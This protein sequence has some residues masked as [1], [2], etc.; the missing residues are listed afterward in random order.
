MTIGPLITG[1]TVPNIDLTVADLL[2]QRELTMNGNIVDRPV[3][4]G[5]DGSGSALHAA[6][7]AADEA[8]RLGARLRLVHA[9]DVSALAW[10][11]KFG[12]SMEFFES[13]ESD[14]RRQLDDAQASIR[15]AHPELTVDAEVRTIAPAHALV[16]LSGSARLVVLGSRG[17]GGF[18]GLLAGSTAIA[19]VTHGHCPVA[20][21]RGRTPGSPPPDQGPVVV[22]VDGSPVS[23]TAL[24]AAFEESSLRGTDLV[25]VHAWVEFASDTSYAY[26]R[27]LFVDWDRVESSEREI[28][29]ERLAGWQE[30]YPNVMVRRVVRGGRPA[31]CLLHEA[32]DA[33]LLVVGS[34]G[35]GGFAG[36][37]LGSTSH[38]LIHH[39]S[40]P[41]LVVRADR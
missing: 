40:C 17:S 23:E 34:R 27:Q 4:A 31:R 33:Q 25:A 36:M 16:D 3:V 35:R 7:W 15:R 38:A 20:V 1:K 18:K 12:P 39:A 26:A 9:I 19:L 37:L 8:L 6:H 10:T 24:A 5:V 28:L 2:E 32:E 13:L 14:G 29:A 30:K 21:I 41:L 11:D 22:G